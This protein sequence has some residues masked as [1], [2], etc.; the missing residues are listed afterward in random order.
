[1]FCERK[2]ILHDIRNDIILFY[3]F[4]K[5]IVHISSTPQINIFIFEQILVDI[6][7]SVMWNLIW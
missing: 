5:Y 3:L 7:N 2:S 4:K 1:M 6:L